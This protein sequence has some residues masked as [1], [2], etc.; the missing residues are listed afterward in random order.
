[1]KHL[2]KQTAERLAKLCA[3]FC[4][5]HP[6]ERASAAAMADSLV[7]KLG[8]TWLEILIS[9]AKAG[10]LPAVDGLSIE[11]LFDHALRAE[12]ANLL[13]PW[14]RSFLINI[15]GQWRLTEKQIAKLR[16]IVAKYLARRAA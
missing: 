16:D 12:D 15:Y 9:N 13:N 5:N 1:M 11:E 2:D 8:M 6:G 7:R 14:E 3:M 10:P 4:S